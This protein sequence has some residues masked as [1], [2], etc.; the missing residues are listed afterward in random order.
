MTGNSGMATAGTMI[1]GTLGRK[2]ADWTGRGVSLAGKGAVWAGKK[3]A[4]V[5]ARATQAVDR[6]LA[7]MML[8]PT[9]ED[10]VLERTSNIPA[11][12]HIPTGY[13]PAGNE[14][15]LQKHNDPEQAFIKQRSK[16]IRDYY[17]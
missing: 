6:R 11:D 5:V 1:G 7:P 16:N 9:K 12:I 3:A 4:P 13:K 2:A 14:K 10:S 17:V 8:A 15:N